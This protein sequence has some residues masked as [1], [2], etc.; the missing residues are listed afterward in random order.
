LPIQDAFATL[1][2]QGCFL[3]GAVC[4]RRPARPPVGRGLRGGWAIR[5]AFATLIYLVA[6]T[7]ELPIFTYLRGGVG[8]I[9]CA[10]AGLGTGVVIKL[11]LYELAPQAGNALVIVAVGLPGLATMAGL[12]AFWQKVTPRSIAATLK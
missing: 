7:I 4:C 11:A 10:G 12:L 9:A 8:I 3:L 1:A 6:R 5:F 2:V